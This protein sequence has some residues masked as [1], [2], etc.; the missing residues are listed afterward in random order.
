MATPLPLRRPDT[1]AARA[2]VNECAILAR[3]IC[4]IY[5]RRLQ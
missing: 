3:Q 1:T 2:A 5:V 4:A